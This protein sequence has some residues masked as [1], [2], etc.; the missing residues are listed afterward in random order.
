MS[1]V[2][3]KTVQPTSYLSHL[4]SLDYVKFPTD[5]WLK[6]FP[7]HPAWFT[8][9]PRSS[10][11]ARWTP[12][13]LSVNKLMNLPHSPSNPRQIHANRFQL[14]PWT[15]TP[16]DFMSFCSHRAKIPKLSASS[17]R[18]SMNYVSKQ[19]AQF[20]DNKTHLDAAMEQKKSCSRFFFLDEIDFLLPLSVVSQDAGA[21]SKS[22]HR[23]EREVKNCSWNF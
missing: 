21:L 9:F 23:S 17:Q 11:K 19:A 8:H 16:P 13:L 2:W 12:H 3:G 5:R 10:P 22:W 20:A 14:L 1:C 4:K 15:Q 7:T 18:G 6:N